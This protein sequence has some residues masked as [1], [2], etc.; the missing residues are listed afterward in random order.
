MATIHSVL[1]PVQG[2]CIT[3]ST[4]LSTAVRFSTGRIDMLIMKSSS[5]LNTS[6][7]LYIYTHRSLTGDSIKPLFSSLCV[8]ELCEVSC[9]SR[10]GWRYL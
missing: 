5:E 1:C 4:P 3:V 6:G 8:Q 9:C 10:E 2:I 7:Q